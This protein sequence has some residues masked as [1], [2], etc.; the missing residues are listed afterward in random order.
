VEKP[1]C[2]SENCFADLVGLVEANLGVNKANYFIKRSLNL[3]VLISE[4]MV[5]RELNLILDD[6]A[7]P[8]LGYGGKYRVYVRLI[9][10]KGAEFD[11]VE[12]RGSDGSLFVDP[13]IKENGDFVEA[14]VFV[15]VN[16]KEKKRIKYVW[17]TETNLNFRSNGSYNLLLRKQAGVDGYDAEIKAVFPPN[18]RVGVKPKLLLTDGGGFKYNTYLTR[19][20]EEGFYW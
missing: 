8:A 3:N 19:D 16:P 4:D 20:L 10:P 7:N 14:G 18:L 6:N 11:A 1:V 17:Q 5:K 13:D 2:E 12:I 15:E 9:A